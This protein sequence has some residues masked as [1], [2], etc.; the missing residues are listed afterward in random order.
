MRVGVARRRRVG[1]SI[2]KVGWWVRER[3]DVSLGVVRW[4]GGI[5][6][7]DGDGVGI[8]T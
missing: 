4:V 6:M 5:E 3:W 7:E 2:F 8:G 1:R